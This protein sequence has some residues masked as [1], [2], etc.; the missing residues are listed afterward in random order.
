[1]NDAHINPAREKERNHLNQFTSRRSHQVQ[2][3]A[4]SKWQDWDMFMVSPA[5]LWKY[6]KDKLKAATLLSYSQT[7]KHRRI[8]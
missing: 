8:E 7:Q 4:H 2:P 1:M 3:L 5:Q 6:S